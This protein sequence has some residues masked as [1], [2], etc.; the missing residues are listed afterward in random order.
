[1]PIRPAAAPVSA[2]LDA[3]AQAAL[4][5]FDN[6][7]SLSDIGVHDNIVLRGTD[8][9]DTVRFSLPQTQIVKTATM[10][11]RYHFSPGL[12]PSLSHI[13]VSLNGTLFATLA[14]DQPA[15]SP[16]PVGTPDKSDEHSALLEA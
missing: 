11:L 3:A 7:F 4:G 12:I 16:A 1:V 8:A 13:K 6:T 14:V 9:S 2:P 5:S 10:K 15:P